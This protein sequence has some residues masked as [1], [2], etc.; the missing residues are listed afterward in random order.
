MKKKLFA[1]LIAGT[2]MLSACNDNEKVA[3]KPDAGLSVAVSSERA[4]SADIHVDAAA[5]L[6]YV[7][8]AVLTSE[9]QTE[10]LESAIDKYMAESASAAGLSLSAF[11]ADTV[12]T[13]PSDLTISPLEAKSNYTAFAV[14]LDDNGKH[15]SKAASASFSTNGSWFRLNVSEITGKSAKVTIVPDADTLNYFFNLI[16]KETFA[17]YHDSDVNTFVSNL[18]GD[19]N[20]W[21]DKTI[22]QI[23]EEI[24]SKGRQDYV[25]RS[26][27]KPVTSYVA[28]AVGLSPYGN[29]T[30]DPALAEFTTTELVSDL[31]FEVNVLKQEW[32]N[33]DFE[34]V[35]SDDETTYWFSLKPKAVIA[36]LS[37]A[38]LIANI[39]EEDSFT[40]PYM[41]YTGKQSVVRDP[42]DPFWMPYTYYKSDTGYE[43]LVFGY[44]VDA[45]VATTGLTHKEMRTAKPEQ[46]ASECTFTATISDL[47]SR[48]VKVNV[49]PSDNKQTYLW[50]LMDEATYKKYS[51]DYTVFVADYLEQIGGLSQLDEHR[52]MGENGNIISSLAPGTKY[53]V[54]AVCV[55]E[56]GNPQ[57]DVVFC[58]EFTT[59]ELV[60]G[61]ATC[62]A[63]FGKYFNGDD[64]YALDK[65]KYADAKGKVWVQVT[66]KSGEGVKSWYGSLFEEDL[67]DVSK[68]PDL[69]VYEMLDNYD[70]MF[71]TSILRYCDWDKP[72]T[73]LSFAKDKD[74]NYGP[75]SRKVMTFT[76][77]GASPVSEFEAS[78]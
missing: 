27:L 45:G 50:D 15:L 14:C 34:V 44:D 46:P 61:T 71:P 76:K 5:T 60:I 10:G 66:F 31:K 77:E 40:M 63:E 1:V 70:Y 55:D 57:A 43:L 9:V 2:A 16:D 64:L 59:P 11:I 4:L 73:A 24:S 39:I 25:P 68:D 35:P 32:D 28:F 20:Q 42:E 30:T 48:E 7:V 13:G 8:G 22:P 54:W 65:D 52:L 49:T 18:L 36:G 53:H 26:A 56:N 17:A 47:K 69:T 3:E 19:K 29:I 38:E 51:S 67:T 12:Q 72:Y 62:T 6:R 21:G 37:D 74:G 75:V 41:I 78:K 23:V 58:T 33:I